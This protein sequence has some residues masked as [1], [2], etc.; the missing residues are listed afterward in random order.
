MN[1]DDEFLERRPP[2]S[3]ADT[4]MARAA[5]EGVRALRARH[6]HAHVCSG[7][8]DP[9]WIVVRAVGPDGVVIDEEWV[10][11]P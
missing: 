5:L 8:D 11:K 4:A 2:V 9:L 1:H 10:A 6:P 3:E 7:Y